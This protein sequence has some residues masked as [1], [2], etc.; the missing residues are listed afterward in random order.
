M[1]ILKFQ[2]FLIWATIRYIYVCTYVRM[3]KFLLKAYM[4]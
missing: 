2:L 1:Y 4:F 3:Y